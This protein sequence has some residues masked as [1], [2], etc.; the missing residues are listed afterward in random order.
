[1]SFFRGYKLATG[2]K[3]GLSK[4]ANSDLL[5]GSSNKYG[6]RGPNPMLAKGARWVNKVRGKSEKQANAP[7]V[8]VG[9]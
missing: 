2:A 3:V 9:S 5:V 8:L 7:R 1:V 4:G 6:A